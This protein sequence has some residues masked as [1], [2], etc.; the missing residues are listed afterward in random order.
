MDPQINN[1]AAARK[2]GVIEP[3][4]VR[5]VSVVKNQFSRVNAA[6]LA[7]ASQFANLL[8]LGHE[9]IRQVD[10]KQHIGLARG[11]NYP[12]RFCSRS[13]KGLLTKD[14]QATLERDRRLFSMQCARRGHYHS[15][16]SRLDQ[17]IKTLDERRIR[18]QISGFAPQLFG[19]ISDGRDF[20]S[21]RFGNRLQPV[22]SNP[23]DPKKAKARFANPAN[24]FL[25]LRCDALHRCHIDTSAFI[26]F[27]GRSFIAFNASEIR[28]NENLCV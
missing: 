12:P 22:P 19:W 26:K 13:P 11:L 17:L 5:A 18:R 8:D 7:G 24:G 25:R 16:Q 2:I 14:G 23:A 6:E 9:P 15:V 1:A 3:W 10:S 4:L 27:F 28:S 21:V 20:N